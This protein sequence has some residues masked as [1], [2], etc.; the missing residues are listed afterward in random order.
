MAT[1]FINL[2]PHDVMLVEKNGMTINFKKSGTVARLD[3]E[4]RKGDMKVEIAD[5]I[6]MTVPLQTTKDNDVH[7]L[8]DP[9]PGVIYIVSYKV[10]NYVRRSDVISPLTDASAIRD[11][12]NN[13]TGVRAFQTFA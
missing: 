4:V 2:T 11:D 7:G 10:A 13:I 12:D 3:Y 6:E 9:V 5:G 8:P 1:K